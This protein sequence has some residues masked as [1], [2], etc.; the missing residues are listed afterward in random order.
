V[1]NAI[2][3]KMKI[4]DLRWPSRSA[5]TSTVGPNLATAGLLV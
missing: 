4:I 5:T 2:S 1:A 3:D